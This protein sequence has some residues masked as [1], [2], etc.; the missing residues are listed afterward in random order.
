MVEYGGGINEGP[1]GQVGGGGGGGSPNLG[2]S[3]DPFANVG[4][5]FNDAVNFI[6]AQ[7]TEI[8]VLAVVVAILGLVV[9]KRAF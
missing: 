6:T 1:A 8:L 2:S 5:M 3:G 9:L 7:P 4:N